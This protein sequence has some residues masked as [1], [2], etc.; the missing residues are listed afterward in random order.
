MNFVFVIDSSVSMAQTFEGM[1]FFEAAKSAIQ[2]FVYKRDSYN[3][4]N[5]LNSDKYMLLTL[6]DDI[7]QSA[8]WNW[9]TSTEHFIYQLKALKQSYDYTDIDN[10]IKNSFNFLNFIRK[11]GFEQHVKGRL[12]SCVQ[13]SFIIVI[14]DG[15]KVCSS[16]KV[17]KASM[18]LLDTDIN[19]KSQNQNGLIIPRLFNELYRW[20]QSIYAIIL[21][22]N[23][24][25]P[26]YKY[27]KN[28][29]NITGGQIYTAGNW[30]N[31][32]KVICEMFEKEFLHK[33]VCLSFSNK[34]FTYKSKDKK[35][36]KIISVIE[37]TVIDIKDKWPFPDELLIT[38]DIRNLP[39]KKAHP[40]YLISPIFSFN[41]SIKSDFY[42]EYEI[43][44][45]KMKFLLLTTNVMQN[46]T[47]SQF[48]NAGTDNIYF[49]VTNEFNNRNANVDIKP[50]AIIAIYFD[51]NYITNL[52]SFN[53]DK[54]TMLDYVNETIKT[55]KKNV[56]VNSIR[57]YFYNLPYDYKEFISIIT[58]YENN[59]ISKPELQI[60]IEKYCSDIPFYYRDYV[61]LFLQRKG[62]I[63]PDNDSLYRNNIKE[64]FSE[65]ILK[66]I[67]RI[68]QYE[69]D[70]QIEINRLLGKNK[71]LHISKNAFC[72]MKEN[73]YKE[74]AKGDRNTMQSTLMLSSQNNKES[75]AKYKDFLKK[76][77]NISKT[78]Q[79]KSSNTH[80]NIQSSNDSVY[81][82][83][84]S[85]KNKFSCDIESMGDFREYITKSANVRS[86]KLCD[87]EIKTFIGDY[88]GNQFRPR[89]ELYVPTYIPPVQSN[90]TIIIST[91]K[92]S[93]NEVYI[94]PNITESKDELS[95]ITP[96]QKRNRD[97]D[98]TEEKTTISSPSVYSELSDNES[99]YSSELSTAFSK[100]FLDYD[101][102]QKEKRSNSNDV[103]VKTKYDITNEKITGWKLNAELRKYSRKF[104]KCFQGKEDLIALVKEIL[105][106]EYLFIN[107]ENKVNFM[108]RVYKLGE[109]YELDRFTL[110]KLN[111][112]IHSY[113]K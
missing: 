41:F 60:Q 112:M 80:Q 48:F 29:T 85:T 10:A 8:V 18:A 13:N 14:T 100:E 21:S 45:E 46:I 111:K 92:D 54:K 82:S 28:Y 93:C 23:K 74:E 24:K 91:Q 36:N 77:L 6:H 7:S 110:N 113:N 64:N 12:F 26:S 106:M 78:L 2:S 96:G 33:R 63:A 50:F 61:S 22:E 56:I 57:C 66:E 35:N 25:V 81:R 27:L 69:M 38:K 31:L 73:L 43:K 17:P 108:N 11:I 72:C 70:I 84:N 88:F 39:I 97:N 51:A 15:G 40:F 1:S 71:Q 101:I 30:E 49:E 75:K 3:N 90:N 59:I 52:K 67:K 62:I 4:K 76:C 32:N 87:N 68:S 95:I 53:S 5:N 94:A 47:I 65:S 107:K 102:C 105:K 99:E 55:E 104:V 98:N 89:K 16:K 83:N 109:D 34:Y 79:T 42:D 9:S 37:P 58:K 103:R 86:N 20:D 44:D 19:I